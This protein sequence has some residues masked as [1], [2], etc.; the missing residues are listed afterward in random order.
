MCGT[1]FLPILFISTKI[2]RHSTNFWN[3]ANKANN[4]PSNHD[5]HVA[6][7]SAVKYQKRTTNIFLQVQMKIRLNVIFAVNRWKHLRTG[8]RSNPRYRR[9]SPAKKRGGIE[10]NVAKH[11]E[12]SV[13]RAIA[14]VH[15]SKSSADR[16]RTVKSMRRKP[17]T[18]ST[19]SK[20]LPSVSR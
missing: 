7:L 16:E 19:C 17:E 9:C 14:G 18:R 20:R 13:P 12:E 4:S 2:K 1:I 5:T 8:P 3:R 15:A 11:H 10:G 6:N